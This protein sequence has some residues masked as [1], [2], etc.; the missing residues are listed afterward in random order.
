[1]KPDL[2]KWNGEVFGNVGRNKRKLFEDLQAFDVIEGSRALLEEE[3]LMK[4]EIVNE[5]ERCSL[6]EEVSWR[7]KSRVMWLK[8]RG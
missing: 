1:L 3:L 2:K 8:G 7:Q 6:L 5:I 4:A